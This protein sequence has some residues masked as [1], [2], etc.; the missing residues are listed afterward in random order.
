MWLW[1]F[2]FCPKNFSHSWHSYGVNFLWIPLI[3]LWRCCFCLKDF[4]H[5]WHWYGSNFLW[6]RVIWFLRFFTD[7]STNIGFLL[8]LISG[9]SWLKLVK[10]EELDFSTNLVQEFIVLKDNYFSSTPFKGAQRSLKY[11]HICHQVKKEQLIYVTIWF[12]KVDN[13]TL[14]YFDSD[15]SFFQLF[16]SITCNRLSLG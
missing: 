3:C 10:Y 8:V 16:Y 7:S 9:F 12:G 1:R 11:C 4:L 6:F 2:G 14:R 15:H 5:S 13:P